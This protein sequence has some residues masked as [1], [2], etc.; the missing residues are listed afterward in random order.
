MKNWIRGGMK[1]KS[2]R[3][4]M[5][6]LEKASTKSILAACLNDSRMSH[7]CPSYFFYHLLPKS[8]LRFS[9]GLCV[10]APAEEPAAWAAEKDYTAPERPLQKSLTPPPPPAREAP[11][12]APAPPVSEQKSDSSSSSSSGSSLH[13]MSEEVPQ[14]KTS[15]MQEA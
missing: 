13:S 11:A 7:T 4:C 8:H 12:E 14:R 5:I 15:R 2:S 10:P 6:L 3:C 9:R 1:G